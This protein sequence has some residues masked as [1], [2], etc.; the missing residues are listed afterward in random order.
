MNEEKEYAVCRVALVSGGIGKLQHVTSVD[1][2]AIRI[3]GEPIRHTVDV[4][5]GEAPIA[6]FTKLEAALLAQ[7]LNA[8]DKDDGSE[9]WWYSYKPERE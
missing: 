7:F 2:N 5:E 4:K 1:V 9:T 6:L 8:R 3:V